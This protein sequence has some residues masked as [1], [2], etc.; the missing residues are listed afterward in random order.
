M[1]L[2]LSHI[3]PDVKTEEI[4]YA[5]RL[6]GISADLNHPRLPPDEVPPFKW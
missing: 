3:C 4:L 6:E 1:G 2:I 5:G